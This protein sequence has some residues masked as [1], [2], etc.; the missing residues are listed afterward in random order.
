MNGLAPGAA[1]EPAA[2]TW[3]YGGVRAGKDGKRR[4]AWPD[5]GGGELLLLPPAAG[6]PPA[7]C[8]PPG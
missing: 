5:P 3:A 6:P 1:P 2:G 8:T 7:A 4:H